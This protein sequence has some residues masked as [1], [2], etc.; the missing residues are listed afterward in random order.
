VVPEVMMLRG[1]VAVMWMRRQ[2]TVM[3]DD[4]MFDPLLVSCFMYD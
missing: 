4:V 2:P 1:G 3:L